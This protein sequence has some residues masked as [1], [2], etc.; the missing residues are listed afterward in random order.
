M[1]SKYSSCLRDTLR[2]YDKSLLASMSSNFIIIKGITQF[3]A[4]LTE[5]ETD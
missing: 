3:T 5:E 4:L 2:L 1:S